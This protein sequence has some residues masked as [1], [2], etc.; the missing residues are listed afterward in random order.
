MLQQ[1]FCHLPG[2]SPARERQLWESGI[3]DWAGLAAAEPAGGWRRAAR[4]HLV[5]SRQR[6]AVGDSAYFSG[7]LPPREHW[8]LLPEFPAATAY[9]DIETTGLR[10][11]S[12]AVTTI[13]LYDGRRVQTFVQGENLEDFPAAIAPFQLLVTYNGKSFDVPFLEQAFGIR[14]PQAHLDLRY[15][16]HS[17]G[18][19]G[20]LKGCERQLGIARGE[21]AGVDGF[22][23]V[24][25]W[26]DYCRTGNP[27]A[28]QTLLAY[29]VADTVNL[30]TLA[31]HAYNRKLDATPFAASAR[32][33][34]PA[35]PQL[36]CRVEE[37][38]VLALRRRLYGW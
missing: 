38:D 18:L 37:K 7:R 13:A 35:A 23:A 22:F 25:L 17:L 6:L 28:R 2:V 20:G 12:D 33:P 15:P 8:R 21:L 5:E 10:R 9:L 30:A 3:R 36:P 4:D 34:L 27:L 24:L 26:Q 16:L 29:N 19:R 31:V 11:G 14:L 1:T 32:L